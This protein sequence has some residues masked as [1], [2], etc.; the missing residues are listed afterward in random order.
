MISGII[1]SID[2]ES[3]SVLEFNRMMPSRYG[4]ALGLMFLE[5]DLQEIEN[6][7]CSHFCSGETPDAYERFVARMPQL[8]ENQTYI[9]KVNRKSKRW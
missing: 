2:I 7:V 3:G 1:K 5:C 8:P 9:P 4:M 6:R